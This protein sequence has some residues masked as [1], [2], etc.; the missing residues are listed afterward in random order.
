MNTNKNVL[1]HSSSTFLSSAQACFWNTANG[2]FGPYAAIGVM[3][4]T[5]GYTMKVICRFTWKSNCE[6]RRLSLLFQ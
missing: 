2:L 4:G 6:E 5:T 3:G 1:H